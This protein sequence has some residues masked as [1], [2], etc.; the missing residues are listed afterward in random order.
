M[1]N[2]H[3]QGPQ[4]GKAHGQRVAAETGAGR[5]LLKVHADT[6][7]VPQ[8]VYKGRVHV[9]RKK[10]PIQGFK[11]CNYVYCSKLPLDVRQYCPKINLWCYS[12]LHRGHAEED[13]ICRATDTN[14][15]IFEEAADI[16]WVI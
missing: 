11:A 8:K 1:D 12:C 4:D 15:T 6:R 3:D 7:Q 2:D 10:G 14:L 5:T 9:I 13:N 16:R